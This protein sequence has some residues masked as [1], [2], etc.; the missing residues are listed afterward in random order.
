MD[1]RIRALESIQA[2]SNQDIN[3]LKDSLPSF[4]EDQGRKTIESFDK[5]KEQI[6]LKETE[7]SR[8]IAELDNN[9]KELENKSLFSVI[10]E[11]P[12]RN[13]PWRASRRHRKCA[14]YLP[15]NTPYPGFSCEVPQESVLGS[16]SFY[17]IKAISIILLTNLIFIYLLRT[18]IFF[19]LIMFITTGHNW[20]QWLNYKNYMSGFLSIKSS[21]M[22]KSLTMLFFAHLKN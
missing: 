22:L 3:D 7:L 16:I 19:M 5:Y 2:T 8:K 13:R 17:S 15:W 10:R 4:A 20:E 9:I 6:N 1:D 11:H 14:S 12:R 21:L 18:V